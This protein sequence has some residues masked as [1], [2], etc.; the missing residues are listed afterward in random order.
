M[1]QEHYVDGDDQDHHHHEQQHGPG[2]VAHVSGLRARAVTRNV[3]C[4]RHPLIGSSAHIGGVTVR[5]VCGWKLGWLRFCVSR[6]ILS[7]EGLC[8]V[9]VPP[10]CIR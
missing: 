5:F 1:P 8:S 3:G 6:V 10:F 2:G 9:C 4:R 7:T